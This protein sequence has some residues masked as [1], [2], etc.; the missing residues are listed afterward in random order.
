MNEEQLKYPLLK[1]VNIFAIFQSVINL[2][3]YGLGKYGSY[4]LVLVIAFLSFINFMI[5]VFTIFWYNLSHD[6]DTIIKN[7][8]KYKYL[9]YVKFIHCKRE[10]ESSCSESNVNGD[11]EKY[12]DAADLNEPLS[13]L[14]FAINSLIGLLIYLYIILTIGLIFSAIILYTIP[15]VKIFIEDVD[16][17][18]EKLTPE[19]VKSLFTVDMFIGIIVAII[20]QFVHKSLYSS[21]IHPI[22]KNIQEY[23]DS[24]DKHVYDIKNQI[25][26]IDVV[27]DVK[28]KGFEYFKNMFDEYN[29]ENDKDIINKIKLQKD[30]IKDDKTIKEVQINKHKLILYFILYKH[31]YD[32]I[33]DTVNNKKQDLLQYFFGKK[34]SSYISFFV[35]D[36]GIKLIDQSIYKEYQDVTDEIKK[37]I[38]EINFK[39]RQVPEFGNISANFI[40]YSFILFVVAVVS[41]IF[42][43]NVMF[44]NVTDEE[45][46]KIQNIRNKFSNYLQRFRNPDE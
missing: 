39:L 19:Y 26:T 17:D 32:E 34:E 13:F 43:T 6:E 12:C 24:L 10:G 27:D 8:L 7:T 3:I 18:D 29:R 25:F 20:L 4:A 33:P 46:E 35:D 40:T 1:K 14:I 30:I 38:D 41:L 45:K 31:L 22:L 37:E 15:I 21:N 28:M 44:A 16:F 9:E 42:H 2:F 11:E 36:R 5:I 23:H